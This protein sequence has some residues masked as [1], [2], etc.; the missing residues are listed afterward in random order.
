MSIFVT[1][2]CHGN[3]RKFNN[4]SFPEQ[5]ELTKNDTVI[6]CGDFGLVWEKEDI[7]ILHYIPFP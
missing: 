6:I 7:V 1:G 4:S 2:D 5:K 3:V